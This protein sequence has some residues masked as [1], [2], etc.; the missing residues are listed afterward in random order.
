MFRQSNRFFS[1]L[2]AALLTTISGTAMAMNI[3]INNPGFDDQSVADN[4]ALST[5]QGW[6]IDS[7][8]AGV[9]NPPD[10]V[11]TGEAGNGMH[12]NTLYMINAGKV[13]QTLAATLLEDTQYT[14]QF[15]IGERSDVSMQNYTI[16][17]K[18]NGTNLVY[19][20]NPELPTQPGSFSRGEVTFNSGSNFG[21][22]ITIEVETN[23]TGHVNLDNFS[24]SYAQN[25]NQTV[26]YKVVGYGYAVDTNT[27]T[28]SCVIHASLNSPNGIP[29]M[30]ASGANC[31]CNEGATLVLT[32]YFRDT[33]STSQHP[34]WVLRTQW[35]YNCVVAEDLLN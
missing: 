20:T 23:G 28:Q 26:G 29:Y 9:F 34:V 31:V 17:V 6:Q 2:S 13:S 8:I 10:S 16:V 19:A 24:L 27:T 33:I 11:F 22:Q 5:V 21:G 30:S 18:S 3:T 35:F 15:D 25:A 12:E 1:L 14:L 32:N 4:G 7:G